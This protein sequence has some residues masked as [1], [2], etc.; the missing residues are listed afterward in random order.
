MYGYI[1][2]CVWSE[3]KLRHIRCQRHFECD[4]AWTLY[5]VGKVFYKL[6]PEEVIS[7][8][9]QLVCDACAHSRERVGAVAP[10]GRGNVRV[11]RGER[12]DKVR[13]PGGVGEKVHGVNR[14]GVSRVD[15]IQ[16]FGL[17]AV[18]ALYKRICGGA[19][20][21]PVIIE[22]LF[23]HVRAHF[24]PNV[25][26]EHRFLHKFFVQPVAQ[27]AFRVGPIVIHPQ[28][29]R[30]RVAPIDDFQVVVWRKGY[31]FLYL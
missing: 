27:S 23:N 3:G 11:G 15:F 22:Y 29:Q 6:G 8:V 30:K 25:R 5:A 13:K 21:I 19:A 7:F 9:A 2:G 1:A 28:A 12:V 17:F 10:V 26:Y 16:D 31:C 20:E 18:A 14:V 24:G 4:M